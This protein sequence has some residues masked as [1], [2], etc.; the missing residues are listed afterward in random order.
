MRTAVRLITP[1]KLVSEE[2]L[3]GYSV[4]DVNTGEI[5]ECWGD[6]CPNPITF[7]ERRAQWGV[8]LSPNGDW[9]FEYRGQGLAYSAICT[10]PQL[11]GP[12]GS[13]VDPDDFDNKY[14]TI[15]QIAI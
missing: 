1:G 7:D 3:Y 4:W 8:A 12:G 6:H 9:I 13:I 15:D 14:Y 10:D 11:F 2:L 5:L